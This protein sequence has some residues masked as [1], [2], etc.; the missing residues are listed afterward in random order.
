MPRIVLKPQSPEYADEKVRQEKRCCEMPGCREEAHHRAPKHRGLNEHYWFCIDHVREYN[1]AWDFF[2]GMSTHEVE[3]HIISSMYGDRKTRRFD[4]HAAAEEALR[5]RAW[6]TYKFTEE[7]PEKPDMNDGGHT[8]NSNTPEHEALALM[9]LTPPV[10]LAAIKARYKE[11]AKK[12]HPDLNGSNP[13]SEE[14]LKRINMAY[15]ILKMAY[16]QFGKLPQ[17]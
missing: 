15:T 5:V 17:R 10:T 11:L 3:E 14:L 2:S 13:E 16:E 1:E 8:I 4:M 7:K 9:G 12:H 6:Q